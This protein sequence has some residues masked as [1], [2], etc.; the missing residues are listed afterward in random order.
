MARPEERGT[1]QPITVELA[2]RC[3]TLYRHP[4]FDTLLALERV[5]PILPLHLLVEKGYAI[6][7]TGQGCTI[8]HQQLGALK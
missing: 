6:H 3:T 1:L 4:D 2:H 8:M 7:W 5:E